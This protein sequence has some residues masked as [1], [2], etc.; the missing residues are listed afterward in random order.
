MN[1]DPSSSPSS[2]EEKLT[3]IG[4]IDPVFTNSGDILF[5]MMYTDNSQL[6]TEYNTGNEGIKI[7]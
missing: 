7:W 6:K 4:T 5:D 1:P 3:P 2:V